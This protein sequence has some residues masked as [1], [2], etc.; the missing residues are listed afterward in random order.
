MNNEFL[1]QYKRISKTCQGRLEER[2]GELRE[3][4]VRLLGGFPR[5]MALEGADYFLRGESWE[6]EVQKGADLLDLHNE[7]F[8]APSS[9]FDR[10]DW[11]FLKEL[12]NSYADE[13]DMDW[14]TYFMQFLLDRSLL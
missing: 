2:E 7:E 5:D 3:A 11:A 1:R 14:L 6:E 13:L 10:E 9:V 4:L 12:V 8:D